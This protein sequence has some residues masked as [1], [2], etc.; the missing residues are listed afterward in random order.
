MSGIVAVQTPAAARQRPESRPLDEAVWQA[1]LAKGRDAEQRRSRAAHTAMCWGSI[2]ALLAT[3]GLGL[4]LTR[5]EVVV[6][7]VVSAAAV[8]MMLQVLRRREFA[9][10]TLFGALVALYNPIVPAFS[11]SGGLERG[12][13]AA[14]AIPFIARLLWRNGKAAARA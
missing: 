5:Y 4:Q 1:W 6:R 2:I 8:A 11:F 14:S 10:A 12:F 9:L 3:A 7:F 13:V